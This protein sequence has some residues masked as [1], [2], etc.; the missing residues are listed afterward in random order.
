MAITLSPIYPNNCRN[1][2]DIMYSYTIELLIGN[3]A[4]CPLGRE[5]L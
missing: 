4:D 1:G 5:A 2:N 3:I